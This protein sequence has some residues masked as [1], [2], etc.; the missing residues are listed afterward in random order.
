[1]ISTLLPETLETQRLSL[2]PWRFDDVDAVLAY[3]T[4][5]EWARYLPV[6]QP[7]EH[8][9]AVEFV[10]RQILTDHSQHPSWAIL[11]EGV[12]IGGINIRF[13]FS[14]RL[15]GLGYS[16]ARPVWDRGIATEAAAAVISAAFEVHRDLN[17]IEATADVRNLAS[18]RVLEKLGMLREG[19]T[20]QNRVVR[21][22]VVD[23]AYY[24]LLRQE[25]A[26]S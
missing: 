15:A 16:T 17:R 20:R 21:G 25:W 8:Q 13:N 7:Y 9:H 24:G 23:E 26:A 19:T 12:V 18:Q 1:M 6:P 2:R 11:F 22:E 10:A 5:E 3:A 14:R 4:D